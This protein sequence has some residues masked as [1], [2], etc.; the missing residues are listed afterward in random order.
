MVV[1]L[2]PVNNQVLEMNQKKIDPVRQSACF[3]RSNLKYKLA[4]SDLEARLIKMHCNSQSRL[5]A[6]ISSVLPLELRLKG[7]HVP[8]DP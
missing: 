1:D 6:A 8:S 3:T 4:S 2:L 5:F 7:N